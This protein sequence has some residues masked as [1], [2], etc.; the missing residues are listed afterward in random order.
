MSSI[1]FIEKNQYSQVIFYSES[2]VG[3][4]SPVSQFRGLDISMDFD[5]PIS[6]NRQVPSYPAKSLVNI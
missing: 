5:S 1:D 2:C 4:Q 3:T 6:V